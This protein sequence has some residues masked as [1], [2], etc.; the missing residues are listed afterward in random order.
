MLFNKKVNNESHYFKLYDIIVGENNPLRKMKELIDF[1]FIYDEL[2]SKYC[3]TNGRGAINPIE[4]F[5]YLLL[6]S[7]YCLS[8]VDL[9]E[10]SRV[11]MAIKFFLDKNPEDDVIHPSSL[12]KFRR[13][14][15][16]DDNLMDLLMKKTVE[17]AISKN[18]IKGNALIID[19]THTVS[20]YNLK[21]PLSTL[22]DISKKIRKNIYFIDEKIK[23]ELPKKP[24]S[25]SLTDEIEYSK[26]LSEVIEN[27][28]KLSSSLAITSDKNLLNEI[29][30]DISETQL[31][32]VEKEAKIGHKN[33]DTSFYGFK[34]HLAM[35]DNRIVVAAT[36]TTGEKH[37]GK[38]LVGLIEKARNVGIEVGTIIGDAAY[39]EKSNIEYCKKEKIDLVSRLSKTVTHTNE[40]TAEGFEFN[41]DAAMYMCKA[42][43]LSIKKALN[44]KKKREKEGSALV[45]TYFFDIKKCVVCPRKE[46]CYKEGAMSKSYSVTIKSHTHQEH[47]EFQK[48]EKF[49]EAAKNRYMIEAKNAELKNSHGYAKTQ[50]SGLFG[51][52]LQCAITIFTVNIKRIMTLMEE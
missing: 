33:S 10:R 27:N 13:Q 40:R 6:K 17:I 28:P 37:D 47:E 7:F 52:E 26:K 41:K 51:M 49:K 20:K 22:Q 42:G 2:Q 25:S 11:D 35:T 15:L 31:I 29:L 30:E 3:H 50:Y 4:M 34:S 36:V 8:D 18:L 14:R 48:T 16:K 43:H 39:S 32:S 12:T 19:S 5:K 24:D 23:A 44:G 38:E 9:V 21:S 1:S 46:G 45:E